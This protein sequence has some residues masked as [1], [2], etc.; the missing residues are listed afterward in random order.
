MDL[1]RLR[2]FLKI[3]ELG[4]LT[5]AARAVHL[6]QPALS[7]SLQQL[8]G[9]LGVA[10]FD[11]RGR[12]LVLSAAGRALVTRAKTLL[13]SA[14]QAA[15]EV[16]RAAERA[17]FDV[18]VGSIDSVA[19]VLLPN[20]LDALLSKFDR[21]SVKLVTSRTASLLQRVRRGEIDLAVVAHSG[22]PPNCDATLVARYELAYFGLKERFSALPKVRRAEDLARF[23]IVEIEPSPSTGL[24]TETSLT[25]AHVS[26]V[27]TV[28]AMILA[29][30]GVG[31]LPDFMLDKREKQRLARATITHDPNCGLF[32][33]RSETWEGEVERDIRDALVVTLR[34]ALKTQRQSA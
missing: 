32:L 18:R 9:E 27:A 4:S 17:Y 5:E 19:T 21:L 14:A 10:L 3:V 8:E 31:D 34:A 13:E 33:V 22:P 2:Q 15:R 7:R 23:P 6:T 25:H 12:G 16:S 1:D 28:K 20:A 29:G 26:N 11:R 30:I 24:P